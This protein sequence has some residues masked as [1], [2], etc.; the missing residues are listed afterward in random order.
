MNDIIECL[1]YKWDILEIENKIVAYGFGH[2]IHNNTVSIRVDGF[3]PYIYIEKEKFLEDYK[4]SSY[5]YNKCDIINCNVKLLHNYYL[6]EQNMFKIYFQNIKQMNNIFSNICFEKN[7]NIYTKFITECNI[8][9][10]GWVQISNIIKEDKNTNCMNEYIIN[11]KNIQSI[12]KDHISNPKVLS[13]DIECYSS[14]NRSF[15]KVNN[16]DDVIFMISL[17][18]E[19]NKYLL[20]LYDNEANIDLDDVIMIKFKN[21][22]D[23]IK[24]YF[25]MINLI[26]PDIIIGYNIL[27]F[28]FKY[29]IERYKNKLIN[30]SKL[31]KYGNTY[32]K[33]IK[34][35]SSAYKANEFFLINTEGRCVIDIYQFIKR[36]YNLE[37]YSL[38]YVTNYFIKESKINLSTKEL[39]ENYKNNDI[40]SMR[41]ICEYCIKDSCLYG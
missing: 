37:Q 4:K 41:K 16:P 34:W 8:D 38:E 30:T 25:D 24:G 22:Q 1:I 26:N 17:I 3:R 40:I 23:L 15:P 9:G 18:T 27:N 10:T 13:V 2:D 35:S 36:N 21:E 12:K 39:F 7:I 11:Y 20:Y 31:K 32:V 6:G 33:K 5:K 29:I 14:D 28:D 19:S